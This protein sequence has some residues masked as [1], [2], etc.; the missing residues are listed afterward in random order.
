[1]R[2]STPSTARGIPAPNSIRRSS[3]SGRM[4]PACRPAR[5]EVL[6]RESIPG[7]LFGET[8]KD[9]KMTP[10]A[11]DLTHDDIRGPGAYFGSLSGPPAPSEA[12][13]D[14]ALTKAEAALVKDRHCAQYHPAV[15]RS[16]RNSA[17]GWA[18]SGNDRKSVARLS[19]RRA[20]RA[21]QRHHVGDRLFA[22]RGRHQSDRAFHVAP[23]RGRET[24]T[25][26]P[27]P[28]VEPRAR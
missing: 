4:S 6:Y 22:G 26:R 17:I 15:C 12:D 18:A 5:Y 9:E 21:R 2:I 24:V 3:S 27:T 11:A 16:G 14:P 13:P 8:R 23:G 10:V 25:V 7:R 19:A 1:M 28:R 20:P